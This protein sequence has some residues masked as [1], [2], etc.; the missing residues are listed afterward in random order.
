MSKYCQRCTKNLAA[1]RRELRGFS[2]DIC[3]EC[4]AWYDNEDE[5]TQ[6]EWMEEME[7]KLGTEE[8]GVQ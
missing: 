1:L 6:R 4:A 2:I 8:Q 7:R 3:L 5:L